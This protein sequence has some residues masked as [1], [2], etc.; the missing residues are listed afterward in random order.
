MTAT[1]LDRTRPP[2]REDLLRRIEAANR[3]SLPIALIQLVAIALIVYL[4]DWQQAIAE[5]LVTTVAIGAIVGPFM[6]GL[7]RFWSSKKKRIED[8]QE[9]T[10]FGEFDKHRLKSLFQ[11]TLRRLRLP[12][13]RLP[14]FV[15]ADKSMNA[16]MMH[17]GMGSLLR[18]M[19]GIYLHRQV[20]HKL[21]A[22]EV[23]DIMGH[24][25]GHYYKHY[26][27]ADRYRWLTLILGSVAGLYVAQLL[28]AEGAFTIM[29]LIACSQGLWWLAAIPHAMHAMAIE[30]LCDD[31][32]AQVH[33]VATSVSGLMKLGA[34]AEILTAVQQQAVFS[35]NRGNLNAREIVEAI[36]AA[37][38]Y[39]HASTAELQA[40]VEKQLKRKSQQGASLGGFLH[41][42]WN[43][44]VEAE[45]TAVFERETQ[46]LK[47]LQRIPRLDWE[48]L[49]DDPRQL[50]FSDRALEKLVALIESQ[51]DGALF[52][53]AEALGESDGMHPPLKQRILYLW[54]NRQEIE[55][56]K[57]AL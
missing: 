54:Y 28:G 13:D 56:A 38:P 48:S 25:L 12:D 5:P 47:A 41:Y 17:V 1:T 19:N 31:L 45:A 16:M 8:L 32:G 39:G 21:N 49:L 15:V 43:S 6:M 52:H 26:I 40:A 3:W 57:N 7:L 9:Q 55:R 10:R 20:L 44:D 37:I 24:E 51:P 50:Q 2:R 42:M 4:I 18:S 36:E 23:Q 11:D 53:T 35:A 29:A 33:G 34:E 46:K 30:Y 22:D 27:L 14:V